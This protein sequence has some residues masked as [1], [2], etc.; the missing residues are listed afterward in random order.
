MALE[1]MDEIEGAGAAG[2]GLRVGVVAG[3]GVVS[4][5]L[6]FSVAF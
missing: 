5:A 4:A 1:E 6:T 2:V 3:V